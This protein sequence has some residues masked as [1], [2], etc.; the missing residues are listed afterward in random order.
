MKA[1]GMKA[2]AKT[3]NHKAQVTWK[4]YSGNNKIERKLKVNGK[5]N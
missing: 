2:K 3:N 5:F 4:I 1:W